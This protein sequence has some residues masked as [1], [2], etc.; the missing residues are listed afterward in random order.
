MA[1]IK[2]CQWSKT[3]AKQRVEKF[4]EVK[5]E[6]VKIA[7]TPNPFAILQIRTTVGGPLSLSSIIFLNSRKFIWKS[8]GCRFPRIIYTY[9]WINP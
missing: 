2:V 8:L 4:F 1:F 6:I 7:N 5:I 3:R 9:N